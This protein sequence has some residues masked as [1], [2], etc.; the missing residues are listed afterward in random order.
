MLLEFDIKKAV[1]ATAFLIE[2][3][4]GSEDMYVLIKKLYYADRTALIKWGKSIT[5]D[6]LASMDQGPVVSTIYDL[7]KGKGSERN[8]I[9]WHDAL[10]RKANFEIVARKAAD[11]GFLSER[12]LAVLRGAASTIDGIRGS[13]GKW[14]HHNCPEWQNPQGSSIPIDPS[15][16]L[17]IAKKS[18][19]QI[20]EIERT[21]EELRFVSYLLG[22]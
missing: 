18:E 1:A 21:Q 13:I 11:K 17:R 20:Q 14:L 19:G 2:R 15:Q 22:A 10:R 16:I 3:K 9:E 5:G 6:S 12:E 4:G 7:F 8:L